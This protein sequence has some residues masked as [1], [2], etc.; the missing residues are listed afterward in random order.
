MLKSCRFQTAIIYD[1]HIMKHKQIII[2][3]YNYCLTRRNNNDVNIESKLFHHLSQTEQIN[4]ASR[5]QPVAAIVWLPSFY[6][7]RQIDENSF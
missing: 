7:Y 4:K 2:R 1:G 5:W 3:I 6:R